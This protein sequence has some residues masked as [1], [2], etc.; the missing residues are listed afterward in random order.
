MKF[1]WFK[2]KS[3]KIKH[4]GVSPVSPYVNS[5]ISKVSACS[6]Y[7]Q[8]TKVE[9]LPVRLQTKGYIKLKRYYIG[10]SYF[11]CLK[12][13]KLNLLHEYMKKYYATWNLEKKFINI[14]LKKFKI[15]RCT[16]AIKGRARSSV[17]RCQRTV[18]RICTVI[19]VGFG[20][21]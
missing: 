5:Y 10:K 17:A 15:S 19:E 12:V 14:F 4:L 3:G 11:Q 18:I 21:T 9:I 16:A 13:R 20:R 8:I 1:T 2:I 6:A 7:C